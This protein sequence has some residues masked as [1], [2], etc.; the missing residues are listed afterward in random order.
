MEQ[1]NEYI[2]ENVAP[3]KGLARDWVF[4]DMTVCFSFRFNQEIVNLFNF[5]IKEKNP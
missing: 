1:F 2:N 3:K 5:K 4:N